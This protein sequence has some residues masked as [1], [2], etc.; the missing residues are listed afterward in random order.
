MTGDDEPG[1]RMTIRES[2]AALGVGTATVRQWTALGYLPTER[3]TPP[4]ETG[5]DRFVVRRSDVRAFAELHDRGKPRP[6][7][8]DGPNG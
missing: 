2:A 6:A 5:P 4:P 8:L 1:D 7:W 3:R